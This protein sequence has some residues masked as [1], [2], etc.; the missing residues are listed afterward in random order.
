MPSS[1]IINSISIL[2][3]AKRDCWLVQTDVNIK[4]LK[5]KTKTKTDTKLKRPYWGGSEPA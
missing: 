3:E 2:E 5:K 1:E 4:A